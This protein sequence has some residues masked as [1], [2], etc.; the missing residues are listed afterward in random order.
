MRV[1][2]RGQGTEPLDHG[3]G[4]IGEQLLSGLGVEG[5]QHAVVGP[6]VDHGRTVPVEGRVAECSIG[7]ALPSQGTAR[8]IQV[9]A[10]ILI[11]D[12]QGVGVHDVTQ[13]MLSI[14][15]SAAI[16]LLRTLITPQIGHPGLTGTV[17]DAG[18]GA[19]EGGLLIDAQAV[20]F[21][22]DP[23]VS[24]GCRRIPAE[25]LAARGRG[26]LL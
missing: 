11:S 24:G 19:V 9:V 17:V 18:G 8:T 1:V 21:E 4:N 5:V 2:R 10:E 20:P 3:V 26:Q 16:L 7:A 13:R 6:D 25:D 15:E 14:A 22:L 12:E 23:L